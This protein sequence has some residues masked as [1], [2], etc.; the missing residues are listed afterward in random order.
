MG[1]IA[2]IVWSYSQEEFK[3]QMQA[4]C[5]GVFLIALGVLLQGGGAPWFFALLALAITVL[6]FARP[7]IETTWLATLCQS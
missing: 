6:M 1:G 4:R 7:A 5:G 2:A 3:L